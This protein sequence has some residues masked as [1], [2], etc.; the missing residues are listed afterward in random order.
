M[1]IRGSQLLVCTDSDANNAI[2]QHEDFSYFTTNTAV[3]HLVI[4]RNRASHRCSLFSCHCVKTGVNK[5][6]LKLFSHH[7]AAPSQKPVAFGISCAG[8]QR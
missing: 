6:H 2:S 5:S 3:I 4:F 8:S 7:I 1:G